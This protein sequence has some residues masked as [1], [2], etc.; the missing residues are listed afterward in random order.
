M[1][2]DVLMKKNEEIAHIHM[3]L[4]NTQQVLQTALQDR[5]EWR[6]LAEGTYEMN[7]L[8]IS[9]VPSM[10]GTNAYALPSSNE[11]GSTSSCNQAMNIGETALENADPIPICKVCCANDAC[12]LILPCLHLCACKS[13]V[14]NLNI[15]PICNSAKA[16]VIEALFG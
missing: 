4:E 14:G 11:L 7:Q 1:A 2:R 5:D 16:N 10:Q 8:L 9:L 15:C 3:E 13:C 12:I 6:Y